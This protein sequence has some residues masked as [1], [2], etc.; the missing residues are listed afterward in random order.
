M[1]LT[2]LWEPSRYSAELGDVVVGR[3]TDVR[4]RL[5]YFLCLCI[6]RELF[7]MFLGSHACLRCKLPLQSMHSVCWLSFAL[8]ML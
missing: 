6:L 4:P 5:P 1:V 3:V 2:W 7:L 8:C